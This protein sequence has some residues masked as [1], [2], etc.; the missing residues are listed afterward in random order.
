MICT[1][2]IALYWQLKTL[3]IKK[4]CLDYYGNLIQRWKI[5][6]NRLRLLQ[7]MFGS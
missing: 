4:Q 5:A 7:D 2:E 3:H 6:V 1:F